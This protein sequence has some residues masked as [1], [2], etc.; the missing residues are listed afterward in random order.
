MQDKALSAKAEEGDAAVIWTLSKALRRAKK[1]PELA[2]QPFLAQDGR[3]VTS[4][5]WEGAC[6]WCFTIQAPASLV[7]HRTAGSPMGPPLPD[8]CARPSQRASTSDVGSDYG[9]SCFTPDT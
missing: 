6:A 5:Q 1:S 9:T 3:C 8:E 7:L 2:L 4:H